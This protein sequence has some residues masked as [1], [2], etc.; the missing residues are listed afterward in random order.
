VN[1][2]HDASVSSSGPADPAA[3]DQLCVDTLRFLAVDAVQKA[4]S[5]H[6][7]LPLGAEPMAYALWMHFLKH[8]PANP[9]WPDRDRFVLSAGRGSM[10]LYALLHLSGHALPLDQLRQFRQWGSSTPGH[11]ERG[12][13]PGVEVT[14]GP[15]GQ[16]F[17]NGV[18]L[19]IWPPSSMASPRTEAS[20]LSA[21][22]SWRSPTTCGRQCGWPR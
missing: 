19:A 3:L 4:G 14:T 9:Q 15:L 2:E 7:G 18:G 21:P 12:V 5:G 6:P 20:S 22:P 1:D 17:G 10:L 8:N 13:T 11:P 16:G